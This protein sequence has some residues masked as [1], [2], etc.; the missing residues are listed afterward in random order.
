MQRLTTFMQV[1]VF[2]RTFREG[3]VRQFFE[4]SIGNRHVETIAD[5]THAVHVHFLNLVS[6]VFTF[7]GVTHAVTFNGMGQDYG[8]F[9]FGFLRFF[10]CRVNFLRI[11]TTTVQRPNLLIGPVGHQRCGFRV[12]TEEVLTYVSAVFGFEGLVVAVNG[13]VHQ[14]D[15]FTAGVFTQQLIPTTAPHDFNNVPASTCK[16][17]FQFVNNL[18]VTGDRAVKTLQVTVDNKDQVVQFFTGGDGDRAFGFR[19]IHLAVAEEG[20][21]GLFRGIFQ[22][23]VFQIFQE[24]RLVDSTD[25]AQPHRDGRELPE[26]RHQFRVRI[27]REAIAVNFLTEV[28][29]LFLGQ[30][31][32]Q[33][34]ASVDARRDVALEVYQVAA[35]LFV[36]RTEE[37]VET[38]IIDRGGRLEGRHVAAQLKVFFRRAQHGHDG[39]PAD[40]RT[41]ATFQLQIARVF[42][43]V[44]NGNSVDVITGPCACRDFH[45]A[46]A[47]FRKQLVNQILSALNTFFTDDRFDRL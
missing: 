44:F 9:A 2:F 32:F 5:V 27:G 40:S 16:D 46:F 39:V 12:F 31:T 30:T 35:I 28:I 22:A 19:L 17:A 1:F 45:A 14:L 3:N 33:E 20:V 11:V 6:D 34:R 10:Q 8:R 7:R 25:W 4:I 42:R 43:F 13:F 37:M 21:N 38:D 18:A 47:S 24:F 41:N 29:H 15:Q 26:F 36:A 23:T